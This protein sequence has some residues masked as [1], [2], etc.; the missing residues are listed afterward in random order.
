M[1]LLGRLVLRNEISTL[2]SFGNVLIAGGSGTINEI[3]LFGYW[4]WIQ[5]A[6]DTYMLCR[7]VLGAG[8]SYVAGNPLVGTCT[9]GI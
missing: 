6:A 5:G 3:G 9:F 7:D 8:V 2:I 4:Y 1:S